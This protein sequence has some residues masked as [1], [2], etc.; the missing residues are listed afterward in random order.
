M[1]KQKEDVKTLK[2]STVDEEKKQSEKCS[3]EIPKKRKKLSE[4][5]DENENV[6]KTKLRKRAINS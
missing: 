6:P 4:V 2:I 3:K 5:L 1:K